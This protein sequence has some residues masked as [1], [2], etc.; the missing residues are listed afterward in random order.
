MGTGSHFASEDRPGQWFCVDYKVLKIEPTHYTVLVGN[1][2]HLRSWVVERSD[3]GVTWTE[4]DRRENND[5]LNKAYAV[6]TFA[7]AQSGTFGKVR[8]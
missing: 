8:L 7:I 4:I 3:D 1:A 5:D 2:G 6:K